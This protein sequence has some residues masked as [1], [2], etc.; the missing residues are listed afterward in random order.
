MSRYRPTR[1]TAM[2]SGLCCWARCG[3]GVTCMPYTPVGPAFRQLQ[4]WLN[5]ACRLAQPKPIRAHTA[6]Q[7]FRAADKSLGG[8]TSAAAYLQ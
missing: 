7:D 1:G 6:D 5:S 2:A 3:H 4:Q 8:A